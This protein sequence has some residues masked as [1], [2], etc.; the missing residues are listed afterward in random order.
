MNR[1]MEEYKRIH[2]KNITAEEIL[3]EMKDNSKTQKTGGSGSGIVVKG[4]DDVA[5]RFSKCCSPVPGDEIVGYITRG[6][7]ISIHR[8]DCVNV[9]G[10]SE[11]DRARLIE[12]EWQTEETGGSLYPTEIAIYAHNRTGILNDVTKVFLEMKIDI[13]SVTTRTSKQGR[14]TL[15]ISFNITGVEQLNRVI[16]K[17]RNIESVI[18]IERTAG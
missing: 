12:A 5:V 4:T 6:R 17:V 14:A 8:T 11:D 16:S 2:Q 10:M 1:L 18:D 9:L 3:A 15:C 13:S 7:G